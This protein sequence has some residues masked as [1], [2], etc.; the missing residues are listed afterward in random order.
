MREKRNTDLMIDL[1]LFRQKGGSVPKRKHKII[2]LDK[3][4]MHREGEVFDLIEKH[5]DG[6]LGSVVKEKICLGFYGLVAKVPY[7]LIAVRDQDYMKQLLFDYFLT[8]EV[9]Q[10]KKD[11]ISLGRKWTNALELKL[12]NSKERDIQEVVTMMLD[13]A[14]YGHLNK[15]LYATFMGQYVKGYTDLGADVVDY[16]VEHGIPPEQIT[17]KDGVR[18]ELD[19]L[20]SIAAMAKVMGDPDWLGGSG[21]NTGYVIDDGRA[22]AVLVDA[23]QALTSDDMHIDSHS[24]DIQIGKNLE[25]GIAFDNLTTKQR[26]EYIGTL[27]RFTGLADE[28]LYDLVSALVRRGG[29]YNTSRDDKDNPIT[30]FQDSQVEDMVARI[31]NNII[32]LRDT[33]AVELQNYHEMAIQQGLLNPLHA[34]SPEHFILQPEEVFA[35]TSMGIAMDE[36]LSYQ[37]KKNMA[38]S[39]QDKLEALQDLVNRIEDEIE[40]CQKE[41]VTN[42]KMTRYEH[43]IM[44]LNATKNYLCDNI[45]I[46]I[47]N[48]YKQQYPKWSKALGKSNTEALVEEAVDLK[49]KGVSLGITYDS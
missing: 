43:K 26:D 5:E 1:G 34:V 32:Q 16:I 10:A 39:T 30:L 23:G 46:G 21:G 36:F 12:I 44:V 17:A 35:P 31:M 33:Y 13:K 42:P 7:S 41:K 9:K 8:E 47:L 40:H 22:K 6:A 49:R 28:A 15:P 45:D 18:Y 38:Y 11:V 19:Q 3:A 2:I 14:T 27:Y 29:V 37:P 4:Q 25:N 24:K 48:A 20:M